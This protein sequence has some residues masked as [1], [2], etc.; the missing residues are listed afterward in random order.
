MGTVDGRIKTLRMLVQILDHER[1]E[2]TESKPFVIDIS[3]SLFSNEEFVN[4]MGKFITWRGNS[5]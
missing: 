3:I 2:P 1:Y 4:T 5:S